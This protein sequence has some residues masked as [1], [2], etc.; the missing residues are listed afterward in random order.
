MTPLAIAVDGSTGTLLVFLLYL[1]STVGVGIWASRRGNDSEEDFFLAGRGLSAVAMALSAVSSGRSAWLVVGASG[2]AWSLGLSA[3]WL[4]PGYILAEALMF[5][6]LGPRLRAASARVDAITVPEVLER[7]PLGPD[8]REGTTRLPL[9]VVSALLIVAFLLTY[10][11]A[12]LS[13]GAVTLQA[14]FGIDGATWVLAITASVVLVYTLLGGYRAVVV[15]DVIQ[16]GFMLVG[17]V[18]LPLLGLAQIGG[19]DA[20]AERLRAIDPT[21]LDPVVGGLA[22]VGGLCIGF[23]SPGNPHI[24]VRHMSLRDPRGARVALVTGTFWNVVMAAGALLMGLVGRALYP[25][26][27]AF[28][29]GRSDGLYGTLALDISHELLFPAFAGFLLATLF[30]A[31]M[32]TCDSQLLVIASSFVRDLRPR[33]SAIVGASG[34]GRGRLAV[35]VALLAAVALSFVT[36]LPLVHGFVLLSWSLLGAAFGPAVVLLLYDRRTSDRGVL[37]GMLVGAGIVAVWSYASSGRTP[38]YE[39]GVAFVAALVTTWCLR[40]RHSTPER[41]SS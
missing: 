35:A 18:V 6:T 37:A 16:A 34:R 36:R 11:A 1:A 21:L 10:V 2:A 17:L 12:Q 27:S 13:A 24:L 9:R 32:S 23:G 22:L 3:L 5:A 33:S 38:T 8:G 26:V 29:G 15:T 19:F 31:V 20:L 41:L 28:A 7:L 14:V 40:A 4:F 30:A 39:L 25:D